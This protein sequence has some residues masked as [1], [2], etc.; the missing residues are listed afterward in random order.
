LG[1]IRFVDVQDNDDIQRTL[2]LLVKQKRSS[3]ARMGVP[4][5]FSI[6][7]FL[8]FYRSIVI[9]PRMR[10]I[11]H[12]T[13][14]DVGG[15]PAATGIGLVFKSCYSLVMSSYDYDFAKF[16]PGRLH[17]REML[18]YAIGRN[19]RQ[20]DFTIGDE[21][22]KL[23]WSDAKLQLLSYCES[24]TAKGLV[25]VAMRNTIHRADTW[26]NKTHRLKY[27]VGNGRRLLHRLTHS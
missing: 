9:N 27:V 24:R 25:V 4:D 14:L 2:A 22:Y 26:Y 20:F 23:D 6:T 12:V 18:Q 10:E 5:V 15:V 19:M 21:P 11:I 3:Y 17:I 7:G 8:D 16:S 13:R 1:E